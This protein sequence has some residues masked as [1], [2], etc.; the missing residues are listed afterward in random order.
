MGRNVIWRMT[1]RVD[2]DS[3]CRD[4]HKSTVVLAMYLLS[5]ISQ[6]SIVGRGKKTYA[7]TR[8]IRNLGFREQICDKLRV[9]VFCLQILVKD[10]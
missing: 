7:L 5:K 10:F 2:L 3:S 4:V 9:F 1:L 6:Y 8:L